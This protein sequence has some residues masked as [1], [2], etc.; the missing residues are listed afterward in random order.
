[1][2]ES[3]EYSGCVQICRPGFNS[4]SAQAFSLHGYHPR[5]NQGDRGGGGELLCEP[6]IGRSRSPTDVLMPCL[7]KC[8]DVLGVSKLSFKCVRTERRRGWPVTRPSWRR[9]EGAV[10]EQLDLREEVLLGNPIGRPVLDFRQPKTNRS[11]WRSWQNKMGCLYGCIHSR[12]LKPAWD[13]WSAWTSIDFVTLPIVREP[14]PS[15]S[16]GGC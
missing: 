16:N 13:R 11:Q 1:M 14:P 7:L 2:S 9:R 15:H 12:V 10:V 5:Q 4:W 6:I 8:L 3:S